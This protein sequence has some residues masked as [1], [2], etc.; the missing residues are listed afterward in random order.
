M[1]ICYKNGGILQNRNVELDI[2][3]TLAIVCVIGGHYFI[4]TDF[5]STP[6]NSPLV[7]LLGML[8]TFTLIGVPLFLMITGYLNINKIVASRKYFR[9]IFRVL[10]AYLIFSIITILFRKFYLGDE[11]STFQ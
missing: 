7:F 2:V 8:Q 1:A 4:N 6:F 3:P 11:F 9:G 5:N 10:S